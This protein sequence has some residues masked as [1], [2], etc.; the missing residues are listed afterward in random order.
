MSNS[1]QR[2]RDAREK[3]DFTLQDKILLLGEADFSFTVWLAEYLTD[4]S[5]ITATSLDSQDIGEEKY[6]NLKENLE[7]LQDYQVDVKFNIDATSL[8][9]KFK[10]FDKII[11]NFPH[12][13]KGIKDQD[14]NILCN[15]ELL[16]GFF[17]QAAKV[18]SSERGKIYVTLK[19]GLPYDLWNL[20]KIAIKCGYATLQ[21]FVFDPRDYPGYAHRRTL[22]YKQG[23]SKD[24]SLECKNCRT[25]CFIKK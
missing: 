15:Q 17:V 11:F 23:I 3:W 7:I 4:G 16:L 22:G 1:S 20:K 19:V 5:L 2:K 8:N 25:W 9:R 6:P 14:R 12:V 18:L 21:S 10:D 13:G 24:D